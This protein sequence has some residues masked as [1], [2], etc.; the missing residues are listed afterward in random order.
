M[1][2]VDKVRDVLADIASLPAD[3]LRPDR[4]MQD[5]GITSIHIMSAIVQLEGIYDVELTGED[6]QFSTASTIGELTGVI[7]QAQARTA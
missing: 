5:L 2:E 6:L 1:A 7:G 3:T 4:P